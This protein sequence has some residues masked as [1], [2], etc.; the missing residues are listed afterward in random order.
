MVKTKPKIQN[1]RT[2]ETSGAKSSSTGVRTSPRPTYGREIQPSRSRKTL[3]K[4]ADVTGL[5]LSNKNIIGPAI[6]LLALV[7][8]EASRDRR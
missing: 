8:R 7:L 2:K 4:R 3:T 1:V 6:D 5:F